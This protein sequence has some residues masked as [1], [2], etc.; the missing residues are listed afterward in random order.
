MLA[1]RVVEKNPFDF[2]IWYSKATGALN[3]QSSWG[4]QPDGSGSCPG[5]FS[6]DNQTFIITNNP[7]PVVTANWTV[8]GKNT[9][10]ILGREGESP[11]LVIPA[12][13]EVIFRSTTGT[14]CP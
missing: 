8:E 2:R 1:E 5:S 10:V 7:N 13:V 4:C 14:G 3:F 9:R 11:Q 12:Q 6:A